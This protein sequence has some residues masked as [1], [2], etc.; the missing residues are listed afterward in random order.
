MYCYHMKFDLMLFATVRTLYPV[1]P[2]LRLQ[3]LTQLTYVRLFILLMLQSVR[4][5]WYIPI[6]H[7][8]LNIFIMCIQNVDTHMNAYQYQILCN[9]Q[10]F[11][12][13][14]NKILFP[15]LS[16]MHKVLICYTFYPCRLCVI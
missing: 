9:I 13:I 11:I 16:P 7:H 3:R 14:K 1:C 15:S 10:C 12:Q 4:S 6:R 2:P 5:V 8:H